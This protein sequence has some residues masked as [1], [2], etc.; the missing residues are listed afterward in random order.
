MSGFSDQG[1]LFSPSNLA[2][3]D[4]SSKSQPK[5]YFGIQN[6]KLCSF[7]IT[8]P[9]NLLRFF[10]LFQFNHISAE[11]KTCE[12]NTELSMVTICGAFLGSCILRL[13]F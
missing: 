7:L 9:Q 2:V 5:K 8:C 6:L 4:V 3:L 1:P 13:N 10:E 11:N 12:L